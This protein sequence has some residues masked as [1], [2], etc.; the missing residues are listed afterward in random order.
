MKAIDM[1]T[2]FGNTRGNEVW[3]DMTEI[4]LPVLQ[5]LHDQNIYVHQDCFETK[6]AANPGFFYKV[7]PMLTRKDNFRDDLA[8]SLTHTNTSDKKEVTD[9][10]AKY[11]P[12]WDK[13]ENL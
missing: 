6:Q 4:L 12:H 2:S 13:K 3:T 7:H 11:R 10:I 1:A 8:E 9:C 5:Y